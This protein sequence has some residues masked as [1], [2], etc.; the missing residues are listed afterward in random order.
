[1]ISRAKI[2]TPCM[3][4]KKKEEKTGREELWEK[5]IFMRDFLKKYSIRT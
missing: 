3:Y 1:M 5:A 4:K 2:R